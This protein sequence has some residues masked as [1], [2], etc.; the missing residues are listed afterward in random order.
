MKSDEIYALLKTKPAIIAGPCSIES[1]EQIDEIAGE[2]SA[3]GMKFLRGGSFKPRTCPKSFQGLG[4]EGIVYLKSAANRHNMFTVT[5][6]LSPAQLD[7]HYGS[8]DVIQVGSRNMASYGFL[9]HIASRTADDHK[10]VILKRGFGAT[11]TEFLFAADYV[12]ENGNNNI[13]LCLR[14]IRTF[15]QIDSLLRFTP[16]LASILELKQRTDY[17]VYFD[18]S[19]STGSSKFVIDIAIGALALGADG[20]LIETHINPEKSLSDSRQAIT[21]YSLLKLIAYAK[22][23]NIS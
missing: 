22:N 15:E 19:H 11:L 13:I 20:L 17:P 8:I 23:S 18:P 21:P 7:E 14:G 9:K 3:L 6:T 5:E 2:L 10:P 4:A 16:D 12:A 1:N